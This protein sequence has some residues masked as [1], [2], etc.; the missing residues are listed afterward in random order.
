[1]AQKC[2][3]CGAEI[4][5]PAWKRAASW[6]LIAGGLVLAVPTIGISLVATIYGVFLRVPECAECRSTS[7]D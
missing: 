7:S 6:P 2:T 5:A 3:K 1:M 4:V